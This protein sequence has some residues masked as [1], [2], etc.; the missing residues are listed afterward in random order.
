MRYAGK[1]VGDKMEDTLEHEHSDSAYEMLEEYLVGRIGTEATIVNEGGS[2]LRLL[3]YNAKSDYC[4]TNR[5]D[6]RG[7]LPSRRY[8]PSGRFRKVSVP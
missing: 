8:R 3:R 6:P 5:L 4:P 1:D 2:Q 7:R